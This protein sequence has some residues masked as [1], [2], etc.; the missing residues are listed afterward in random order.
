VLKDGEL[1]YHLTGTD[2]YQKLDD[3]IL[4]NSRQIWD[5]EFVSENDTVY[6]SA[7]LAYKIYKVAPI[8]TL[9]E[10]TDDELLKLV[11]EH[12]SSNY[13]E[14]YVKGVHDSDAAKILRVLVQK[15]VDLGLL[16][17][18]PQIRSYAQFFW[19]SLASEEQNLLNQKLKASGEVLQYFPE[20]TTSNFVVEALAP[21]RY[22][23]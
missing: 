8:D 5:Q 4:L 10:A 1:A 15:H 16:R 9:H 23:V 14:G 18:S 6:R 3:P 20:E 21:S 22:K 7:Y 12:S 2:F 11:Q 19:N 13:S 17:F